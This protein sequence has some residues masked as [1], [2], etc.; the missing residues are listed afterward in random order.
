MAMNEAELVAEN[1]AGFLVCARDSNIQIWETT[2][3]IA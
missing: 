1:L 2:R 3:R